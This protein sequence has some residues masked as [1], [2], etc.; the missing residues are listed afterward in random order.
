M[1]SVLFYL[2][3]AASTAEITVTAATAVA[4][5][6]KVAIAV[7][8]DAVKNCYYRRRHILPYNRR[9]G[10]AISYY[11]LLAGIIGYCRHVVY[12]FHISPPLRQIQR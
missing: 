12:R 3:V 4:V 5:T 7:A 8:T 2:K 6:I 9:N 1:Q 11:R 10:I